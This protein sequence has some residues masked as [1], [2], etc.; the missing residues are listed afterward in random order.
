MA[1]L[2]S[3]AHPVQGAI[4]AVLQ[5][6]LVVRLEAVD[7]VL[8]QRLVRPLERLRVGLPRAGNAR[9]RIA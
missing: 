1:A 8:G 7:L 3:V 5:H 2:G 6:K 4:P 9:G